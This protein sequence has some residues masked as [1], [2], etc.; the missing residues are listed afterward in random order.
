[1]YLIFFQVRQARLLST[2]YQGQRVCGRSSGVVPE[3]RLAGCGHACRPR[4]IGS[5]A[6]A[7]RVMDLAICVQQNP[8]L[9]IGIET[10]AAGTVFRYP[11][12]LPGTRAIWYWTGFSYFSTGLL[13]AS[14]FL[15]ITVPV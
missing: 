10:N 2:K 3:W 7:I 13:P 15:Y 9:G 5:H 8:Y 4:P 11:A 12:S 1:V 6:L 14:A